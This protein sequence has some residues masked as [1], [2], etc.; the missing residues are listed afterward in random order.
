MTAGDGY[1]MYDSERLQALVEAVH[2]APGIIDD[3]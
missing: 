3:A 2:R 1:K